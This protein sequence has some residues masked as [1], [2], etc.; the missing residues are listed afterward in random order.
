MLSIR[1]ITSV[2]LQEAG[3]I[4]RPEIKKA[5]TSRP[6]CKIPKHSLLFMPNPLIIDCHTHAYP[7]AITQDPRGWAKAHGERH[8]SE[9]VAPGD[10]KSIQGWSTPESMI[11]AMNQAGVHQAV[12][13]GWYWEHESTC[14]LH[15][16]V[17]LEWIEQYP[18]RLLGFASIY[19]NE[20]VVDQ[21]ETAKAQGFCGVGEVHI[22]VQNLCPDSSV[23]GALADWL[24]AHDWPINLHVTEAAGH[25]LRNTPPT[26]LQ[27][28]VRLKQSVPDLKII[29]AHW[30][31]GLP[32][33]EQNPKIRKLFQNVY[34]DVAAGPLLYDIH[35]F[36]R[37]VDILGVDKI[38]FGSDYPLRLYPRLRKT[39]DMKTYIDRIRKESGLSDSA[40][41]KIF[42]KNFAGLIPSD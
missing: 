19:P 39:P 18:E 6:S 8:W 40:Q 26:P 17:M 20:Q 15:N 36:R 2:P 29:L 3:E 28:F 34:Y 23:W 24:I 9:L 21:L 7:E 42:G 10:G 1:S 11:Q 30:G 31:G 33:F 16:Q 32:F 4:L 13:L 25:R 38:L 41:G 22:G 37:M 27:H 12:L 35:I 14:R 5:L